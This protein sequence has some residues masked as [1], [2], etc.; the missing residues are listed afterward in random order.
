VAAV[1]N[2]RYNE[3][4]WFYPS[5][6]SLENDRYV[7]YNYKENHWSTGSIARTS[8]V[9]VGIFSTPI[10]MTPAGLAV[11]HE[12]GNQTGG[13]EVFAE[14]GPVQ[15][16]TGDAVMSALMLIPDEKTQGQVTTTFRARYHPNDVERTYGPYSMANPTDLRF[17]GRQVSMRVIG[18]QNTDWRWG[19]PR[20]DVRQGGLR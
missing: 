12:I 4:W 8:G 16:A 10:W 15:I 6:G 9:D 2:A 20:I 7:T 11:N 5:S 17:T 19:V 14:S 18:E 3:I 13:A 1:A